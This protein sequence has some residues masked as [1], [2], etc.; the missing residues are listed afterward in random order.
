M[1]ETRGAGAELVRG[2]VIRNEVKEAKGKGVDH[3]KP[4]KDYKDFGFKSY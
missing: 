2:R 4:C 3:R 1:L